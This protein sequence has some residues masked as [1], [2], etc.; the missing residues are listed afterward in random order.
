MWPKKM[1]D[2]FPAMRA[3][4]STGVDRRSIRRGG[5]DAPHGRNNRAAP[6]ASARESIVDVYTADGRTGCTCV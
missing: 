5:F 3:A 6:S 1:R 2:P 4:T